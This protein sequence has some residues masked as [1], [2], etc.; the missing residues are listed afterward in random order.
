[1]KQKEF[2]YFFV[3]FQVVKFMHQHKV[4]QKP[5]NNVCKANL[6]ELSH[7]FMEKGKERKRQK[8]KYHHR[9]MEV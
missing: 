4:N 9:I 5:K 1:M 8:Q 3:G 2:R 7:F 6:R